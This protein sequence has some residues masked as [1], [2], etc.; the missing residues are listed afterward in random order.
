[1]AFYYSTVSTK[2]W[3]SIRQHQTH[4][5]KKFLV[6]PNLIN[7][8]GPYLKRLHSGKN[9][10]FELCV[11]VVSHDG[12]AF[13]TVTALYVRFLSCHIIVDD[14]IGICIRTVTAMEHLRFLLFHININWLMQ[15]RYGYCF[16][17]KLLFSNR[18][19]KECF[20]GQY[21]HFFSCM[22]NHMILQAVKCLRLNI[23]FY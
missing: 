8:K 2:A 4:I 21:S 11:I 18:Q 10:Y 1:M 3:I 15:V 7:L 22:A 9:A 19:R 16:V 14:I 5:R 12:Y 6:Q 20:Y 13:G 17:G 23:S